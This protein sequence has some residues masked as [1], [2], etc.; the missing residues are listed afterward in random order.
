M[1]VPN[2]EN[3]KVH[4]AAAEN[5]NHF[6]EILAGGGQYLLYTV[7]PLICQKFGI[8]TVPYGNEIQNTGKTRYE[9]S[10]HCIMDSGLFSLMFG[11]HKGNYNEE[12]LNKW[13]YELI[14]YVKTKEY[15]GTCVEIDCQK[16]FGVEKAWEFRERMKND[17][18]NNRQINVFHKEDGKKGLERMIE[19]SDYIAISVP[20]LRFLGQKRY[21]KDI[22]YFIKN[23]KPSIDIHLLGCTELSLLKDLKFCSSSDS[24]S[25]NSCVRYGN[26][27]TR[28]NT[29]KHIST[30]KETAYSEYRN[31]VLENH[32]K[33]NVKPL[34]EKRH[35]IL[36]FQVNELKL[37]YTKTVGNQN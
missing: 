30:I 1:I 21:V 5:N 6:C 12:F 35:S 29:K 11:A 28:N 27:Q 18:P 2:Q 4:F 9:N 32:K 33:F 7:F 26:I 8:K 10:K 31:I 24:T 16:I 3:I 14:N 17:L 13:Y 36:A 22:A 15:L 19:F 25:W 23:K 20:E 34:N 37:L